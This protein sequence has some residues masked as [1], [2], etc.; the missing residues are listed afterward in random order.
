MLANPPFGVKWK[1]EQKV[2]KRRRGAGFAGA[3]V[4]GCRVNDGSLLFLQHMISKM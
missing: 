2:G 3:S 4:P 1:D